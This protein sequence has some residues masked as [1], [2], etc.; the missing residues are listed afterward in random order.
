MPGSTIFAAF[1][2]VPTLL[3]SLVVYEYNKRLHC[4]DVI[5]KRKQIEIAA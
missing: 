2:A 4:E 5:P 3:A 1:F